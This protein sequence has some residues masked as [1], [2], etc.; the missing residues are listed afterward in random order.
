M[1]DVFGTGLKEVLG[2]IS[3]RIGTAVSAFLIGYGL[4]SDLVSEFVVAAGAFLGVSFD[5][6]LA[7]YSRNRLKRTVAERTRL[8]LAMES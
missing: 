3:R 4:P 1:F 5:I 8:R 7:I 2:H 6:G